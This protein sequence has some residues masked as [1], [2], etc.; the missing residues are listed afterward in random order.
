MLKQ[1][2]NPQGLSS[3][4][5][6]KWSGPFHIMNT[7]PNFT[8][9]LKNLKDNKT[10]KALI[11]ASRLKP[12]HQRHMVDLPGFQHAD[13]PQHADMP[14]QQQQQLTDVRQSNNIQPQ[15]DAH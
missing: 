10:Q 11:S 5:T 9:K 8:Y 2:K 12:Y 15:A 13:I 14:Q 3:K 1:D 6:D 7:G 4:H